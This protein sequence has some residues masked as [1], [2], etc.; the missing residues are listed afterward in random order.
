MKILLSNAQIFI[1]LVF[2]LIKIE[3]DNWKKC[4]F[5]FELKNFNQNFLIQFE[6][7]LENLNLN[8]LQLNISFES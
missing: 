2:F 3:N 8:F 1:L 4:E 5:W 7:E 6:S